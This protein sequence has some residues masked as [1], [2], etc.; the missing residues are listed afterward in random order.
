LVFRI[1]DRA[2]VVEIKRTVLAIADV[3][4]VV[5]YCDKIRT[6]SNLAKQHFLIG[7]RPQDVRRLEKYISTQRYKVVPKYLFFDIPTELIWDILENKYVAARDD[8]FNNPRYQNY[9]KLRV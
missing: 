4:Q 5:G 9:I 6:E 3:E 2:I 8:C 1:R 7:K